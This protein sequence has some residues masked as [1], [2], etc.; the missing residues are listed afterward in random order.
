MR[1]K[2]IKRKRDQTAIKRR[3]KKSTVRKAVSS[4]STT[5]SISN[6]PL[7]SN[8]LSPS[9]SE[10][11]SLDGEPDADIKIEIDLMKSGKPLD[12]LPE[13]PCAGENEGISSRVASLRKKKTTDIASILIPY[14]PLSGEPIPKDYIGLVRRPGEEQP[15]LV[16]VVKRRINMRT[17]DGYDY[18]VH[19]KQFDRRM[20]EWISRCRF[21]FRPMSEIK[22]RLEEFVKI[23]HDEEHKGSHEHHNA[24]VATRVKNVTKIM[25][26]G[27]FIDTWYFSPFPVE[28]W[29]TDR[30]KPKGKSPTGILYFCD[31]CLEFFPNTV[32]LEYHLR[33]CELY[34]PPGNEI[35][36][37]VNKDGKTLSIFEVDGYREKQWCQNLSYI[38]KLFLDHKTLHYDVDPFLFYILTEVDERGCQF[39]SYFSKEKWSE[40][41]NNLACILTLPNHQRKGY[42][43][44]LMSF[45]YELSKLEK[46]WG[47]PEKPLSDLGRLGYVKLW[48]SILMDFLINSLKN[49]RKSVSLKEIQSSTS[50]AFSDIT[51]TLKE[52]HI[53]DY[54]MG[55]WTLK[56]TQKMID[57][58][59]AR[60]Q[61]IAARS[62]KLHPE[63]ILFVPYEGQLWKKTH[64]LR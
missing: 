26:G 6:S 38:A 35:Y 46:T 13:K 5:S 59:L 61:R 37:G 39:V 34:H 20:D 18:Y 55:N 22:R 10:L 25:I 16:Q 54:Y 49:G 17:M 57:K 8:A 1:R 58:H 27:C 7:I 40:L 36:R 32:S 48:S 24:N 30:R 56:L 63:K 47:S 51:D 3:R 23:G 2:R 41:H 28:S 9:S 33:S 50:F 4:R 52:M 43:S 29:R 12:V 31:Y 19:Y 14:D 45:S 15:Q 64:A 60:K 21:V 11:N 62:I 53:L 42:G 44:F